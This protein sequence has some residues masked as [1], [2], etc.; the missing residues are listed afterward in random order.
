MFASKTCIIYAIIAQQPLGISSP[1][2]YI[3][4]FMVSVFEY[5]KI[6][7]C[8]CNGFCAFGQRAQA[9]RVTEASRP[10]SYTFAIKLQSSQFSMIH[11]F[12]NYSFI[13]TYISTLLT[14]CF[15]NI[16]NQIFH[17]RFPNCSETLPTGS[18]P[19]TPK[20]TRMCQSHHRSYNFFVGVR[21]HS[22]GLVRNCSNSIAN[23]L[24]LLASYAYVLSTIKPV[25]IYVADTDGLLIHLP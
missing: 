12:S 1:K 3:C 6:H 10:P 7:C 23:G 15:A 13:S 18:I 2:L 19:M 20:K 21:Q 17:F 22:D 4:I 14:T 11:V 24:E 16:P 8:K 25:T 5:L 9:I